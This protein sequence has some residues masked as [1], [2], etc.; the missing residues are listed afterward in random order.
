MAH[1]SVLSQQPLCSDQADDGDQE[2]LAD[3]RLDRVIEAVAGQ[4]D[5]RD[6]IAG[7][8]RRRRSA[9]RSSRPCSKAASRSRS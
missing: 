1:V 3:L 6:L 8:L 7:L 5:E 4:R 9:A 2:F